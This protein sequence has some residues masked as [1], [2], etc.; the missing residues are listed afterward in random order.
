M[1]RSRRSSRSAGRRPTSTFRRVFT[2]HDDPRRHRGADALARRPAAGVGDHRRPPYRRPLAAPGRRRR[3]P[4][5]EILDL[6]TLVLHSRGDQIER[7]RARPAPRVDHRGARLV[8]PESDNHIVLEDEPAW[9]VFVRRAARFL[10]AGRGS[11]RRT[12][13]EMRRRAF[14]ARARRPPL[15]AEG[16]DNDA[17]AAELVLSRPHR[18][19]ASPERLRE[20]RT[21]GQRTARTAAVARL[22]SAR[23]SRLRASRHR[24][25]PRTR[26]GCA[27]APM[28]RGSRVPTVAFTCQPEESMTIHQHHRADHGTDRGP[29]Q[30]Q[31]RGA[32]GRSGTTPP[33]S[34]RSSPRSGGILVDAVECSRAP[35]PRRR[36][37]FRHV[38]RSRRLAR[39]AT[40]SPPT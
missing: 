36:G 22:L 7:L 25:S 9:P 28:R 1:R 20:A 3:G 33:S 10:A 38:S 39:G 35:R 16:H 8:R 23:L 5:R 34:T 6:P 17:I 2:S 15:A 12:P 19:A 11:R 13:S 37:R 4:A 24:T 40:S 31:A 32:C 18:R 21:A 30:G 26:R 14:A 27:S 29:D